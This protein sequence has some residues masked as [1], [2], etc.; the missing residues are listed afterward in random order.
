MEES[1]PHSGGSCLS[2][3]SIHEGISETVDYH[4]R[5]HELMISQPS[6]ETLMATEGNGLTAISGE[7][8]LEHPGSVGQPYPSEI[9]IIDWQQH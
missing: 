1:L 8:W 2:L 9:K 3:H 6:K 5:P 7:E 4:Q